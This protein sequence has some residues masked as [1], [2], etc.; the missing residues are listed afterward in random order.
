MSRRWR[1]ADLGAVVLLLIAFAW[2]IEEG[3][4]NRFYFDEW[5]WIELRHGGLS[6]IFDAYNEHMM[7][8]PL[9]VYQLFFH[10]IGLA[11][12]H[13]YRLLATLGHLL[14]VGAVYLFCRARIGA[15]ALLVAIPVAFLGTGWE[16]ILWG[17]N[18]GFTTSLALGILA[19]VSFDNA[20]RPAWVG[21]LLLCASLL[22]AETAILFALALAIELTWWDRNL[23][24]AWVWVV[25][26]LAY[27]S[28]YVAFFTGAGSAHDLTA[29]PVFGARLAA[30]A[31]GALVGQG[32]PGGLFGH[33]PAAGW[34][35]LA[36][37]IGLLAWRLIRHRALSARLIALAVVAVGY[38]ALVAYGRAG[39]GEPNA[40]RYVY[41]GA[42][43]LTLITV[44]S[45]RE[46]RLSARG[47]AVA[48][49]VVAVALVGNVRAFAFGEGQLSEGS[50]DV[51]AE[52]TALNVIGPARTPPG[53]VLDPHWAP[54]VIAGLYFP[55]TR[56]LG[57]TGAFTLAQLLAGTEEQRA[58][59][60]QVFVR[61]GEVTVAAARS[62]VRPGG[63]PPTA[64]F[65]LHGRLSADG[66]C[67][68]FSPD[69]PAS[70]LDVGPVRG[71]LLI[72][73]GTAQTAT[74]TAA[75]APA[76]ATATAT[77]AS[78]VR[79]RRF[80][81]GYENGPVAVI[82]PGHA[83]L[84]SVRSDRVHHPW[85]VRISPGRAVL[86]CAVAGG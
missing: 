6:A 27:L 10:T 55:A 8:V 76:T 23:R 30:A 19:F 37:L 66:S 85:H 48:G 83:I 44:E 40:S 65:R 1:A 28:W 11:H 3:R 7:L 80:A 5:T 73:T 58:D 17:I 21:C 31:A 46:A 56:A 69:G 4:G 32:E 81:S 42:I 22:C 86:V 33:G 59:A 45:L 20:D 36:A 24:R 2:L 14:V 26:I 50:N 70:T 53:F 77:A 71:R 15:L 74:A 34:V 57:G 68:H 60:D 67:L 35:V 54:Q 51:A 72:R 29:I 9:A 16:F 78:A 38:W 79:V 47:L 41:T 64:H 62:G 75:T 82:A 25:P 63:S 49:I 18:F 52:L 39:L 13:W 43:M 84:L 12:Y 61:D